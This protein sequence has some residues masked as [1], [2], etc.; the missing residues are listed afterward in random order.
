MADRGVCAPATF[1][2][3]APLKE[4]ISCLWRATERLNS[5]DATNVVLKMGFVA[6]PSAAATQTELDV[7][8]SLVTLSGNINSSLDRGSYQVEV[9]L[10]CGSARGRS[11][12][13]AHKVL[14][15][16]CQCVIR[17]LRCCTHIITMLL[18]VAINGNGDLPICTSLP[19]NWNGAGPQL[20]SQGG[21]ATTAHTPTRMLTLAQ[22]MPRHLSM[23]DIRDG[24][25]S[26]KLREKMLK[27][28]EDFDAAMARQ[29]QKRRRFF[30]K[31]NPA[32]VTTDMFYTALD[33]IEKNPD[34]NSRVLDKM[35][36]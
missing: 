20:S 27:K 9:A 24:L 21:A 8:R 15:A 16:S 6:D 13:A 3:T 34:G 36:K 25:K 4:Y 33:V 28:R 35:E 1:P 26:G 5:S 30:S 23:G 17:D 11:Q 14:E 22:C 10:Q 12:W 18:I 32:A 31:L 2:N 29:Q 19:C 7:S